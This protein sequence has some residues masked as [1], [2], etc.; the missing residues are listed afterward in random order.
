MKV[1]EEGESS[2]LGAGYTGSVFVADDEKS[3][4]IKIIAA[5]QDKEDEPR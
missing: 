1:D 4:D 5:S 3:L 2:T